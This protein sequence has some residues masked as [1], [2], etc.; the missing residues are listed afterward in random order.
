LV[1]FFF[2]NQK[3]KI[4]V[5]GHRTENPTVDMG[6]AAYDAQA[7]HKAGIIEFLKVILINI[8]GFCF[9]N[10]LCFLR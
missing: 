1:S 2:N 10:K 3:K 4:N 8:R 5:Q 7:L 6:A 9:N